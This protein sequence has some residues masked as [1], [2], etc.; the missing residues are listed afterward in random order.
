VRTGKKIALHAASWVLA[1]GIMALLLWLLDLPELWKCL[2]NTNLLA[3]TGAVLAIALLFAIKGLRW[4]VLARPIAGVTAWRCIR[5][6]YVAV[7][8]N[9]FIPLRGGD[10]ARALLLAREAGA[11]KARC[12]G[13]VAAD[14]LFDVLFLSTLVVPLVFLGGLPDW[15]RWPPVAAV[16]GALVFMAT[17]LALR[18]GLKRRDR[19]IEEAPWAVR[20][21]AKLARGFDSM[22]SP[23]PALLACGLSLVQYGVLI[24]SMILALASVG[25]PVD[26]GT[27]IL[28]TL[29]VQF[30]AGLPLTPSAAGTM[31]GA[32][33]AVLLAVDVDQ[34]TGMSAAV[35]YHAAQTLPILVLGVILARGT[36]LDHVEATDEEPGDTADHGEG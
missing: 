16:A 8:L 34:E 5:L 13:T 36:A 9:A 27:S 4:W 32:I 29:A 2:S 7:F 21:L 25:I 30:S 20:T 23:G 14:K 28:A 18:I 11:S 31:H 19:N 24:L 33:T 35:I 1:A 26:T 3:A 17:G 10:V 22:L 12:L 6:A 15:I